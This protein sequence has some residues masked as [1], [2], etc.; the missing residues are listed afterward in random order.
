MCMFA[1]P[2]RDPKAY[3]NSTKLLNEL[4]HA[5]ASIKGRAAVYTQWSIQVFK[6]ALHLQVSGGICHISLEERFWSILYA[7]YTLLTHNK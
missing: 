2:P 5:I 7:I 3:K 4:K 6:W 1:C